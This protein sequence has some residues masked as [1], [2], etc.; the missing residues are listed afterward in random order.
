MS[1]EEVGQ[2]FVQ[3]RLLAMVRLGVGVMAVVIGLSL[4]GAQTAAAKSAPVATVAGPC[5]TAF[6]FS[7]A[8]YTTSY[9]L[10]HPNGDLAV[11]MDQVGG[12]PTLVSV[13]VEAGWTVE[14]KGASDGVQLSFFYQGRQAIDFK[15]VL[16]KT[17]IRFR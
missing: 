14:D 5:S 7:P 2:R 10:A 12:V 16:G 1:G 8:G 6:E 17:D 3:Q 13:C 15:Y 11:N 9:P 4:L